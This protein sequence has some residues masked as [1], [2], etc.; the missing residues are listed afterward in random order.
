MKIYLVQEFSRADYDFSTDIKNHGLYVN[1]DE[2]VVRARQVFENLKEQYA[3][4]IDK[5]TYKEDNDE[6]FDEDGEVE[7]DIDEDKGWYEFSFGSEEDF[8]LFR[9]TVE[10]IEFSD[11]A[12][13]V[14]RKCKRELLSDDIQN[15]AHEMDIDLEGKDIEQ[16]VLRVEHGLDNNEGL[17]ESYWLTIEDVLEEI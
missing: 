2:A 6:Y 14:H 5:Y 17:W 7:F 13:V 12:Y 10:E 11:E 9:V 4:E 3:K 1:R 15:K 8:E 16:I